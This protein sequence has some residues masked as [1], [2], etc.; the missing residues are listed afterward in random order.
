MDRTATTATPEPC[1]GFH[2]LADDGLVGEVERA[3]VPEKGID[4][5]YLV[6][7]VPRLVGNRRPVVSRALVS[8]SDAARRVIWVRGSR[9]EIAALPEHLPLEL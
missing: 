9:A 5:D 6:V 3:L 2:V 8:E 1:E 4:P 7:R